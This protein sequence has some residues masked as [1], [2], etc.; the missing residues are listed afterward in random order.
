VIDA[1]LTRAVGAGG[2]LAGELLRLRA[3]RD[4]HITG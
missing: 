2:E 4:A 3:G 1:G